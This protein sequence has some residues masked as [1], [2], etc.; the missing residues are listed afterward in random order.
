MSLG[1][2]VAKGSVSFKT[3]FLRGTTAMRYAIS[4]RVGVVAACTGVGKR[5]AS[6]AQWH[7]H[8]MMEPGM[9]QGRRIYTLIAVFSSFF[10]LPLEDTK[11]PGFGRLASRG[12]G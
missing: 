10:F 3:D 1:C 11:T 9:G 5:V 7:R 6:L 12:W 8:L 4:L 2:V